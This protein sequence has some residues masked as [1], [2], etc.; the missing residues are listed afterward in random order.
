MRDAQVILL[1]NAKSNPFLQRQKQKPSASEAFHSSK[2]LETIPPNWLPRTQQRCSSTPSRARPQRSPSIPYHNPGGGVNEN[3]VI[4][5]SCAAW[6][7]VFTPHQTDPYSRVPSHTYGRTS[8]SP[9]PRSPAGTHQCPAWRCPV[10]RPRYRV[11]GR[12]APRAGAPV[13]PLLPDRA[14]QLAVATLVLGHGHACETHQ[15]GEDVS[16]HDRST[17]PNSLFARG[18]RDARQVP[19]H[20][21]ALLR[22]HPADLM[23]DAHNGLGIGGDV[24]V[25]N[26]AVE[27]GELAGAAVDFP[28]RPLAG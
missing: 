19:E 1:R 17:R 13:T 28:V 2:V 5:I 27:L 22:R 14:G 16:T 4:F 3:F 11:A 20:E 25:I 6:P 18:Q 24:Q 26:L 7:I 9:A 21:G 23:E 12:G 10:R 8:R 15:R